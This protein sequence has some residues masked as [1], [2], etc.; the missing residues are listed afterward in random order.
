M[1]QP[2]LIFDPLSG[3]FAE[4]KQRHIC[5]ETHTSA[6]RVAIRAGSRAIYS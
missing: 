6:S 2:V 3:K 1:S 5:R 4:I